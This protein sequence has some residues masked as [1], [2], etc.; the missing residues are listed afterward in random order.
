[1][2]VLQAEMVLPSLSL[3]HL[4]RI[5]SSCLRVS[6]RPAA[7]LAASFKRNTNL[8]TLINEAAA[9]DICGKHLGLRA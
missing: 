4:A 6:W 7:F 1:M 2:S 8:Q 5:A 9:R 3:S